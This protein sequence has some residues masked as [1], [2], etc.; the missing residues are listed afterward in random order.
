MNTK[1]YYV[2]N[3]TGRAYRFIATGKSNKTVLLMEKDTHKL[4]RV[5]WDRFSRAYSVKWM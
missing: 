3:K 4:A 1:L 2:S 5:P